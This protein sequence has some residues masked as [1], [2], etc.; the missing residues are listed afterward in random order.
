[1]SSRPGMT[2]VESICV[3]A[4]IVML[5]AFLV[6]AIQSVRESARNVQCKNNLRNLGLA[7]QNY[8]TSFQRLP[9]GSLGFGEVVVAG[10]EILSAWQ[11][12]SSYEYYWKNAQH[13]SWLTYLLAFLEQTELNDSLPK[14]FHSRTLYGDLLPSPPHSWIGEWS[15]VEN[16]MQ[17][18]VP[19]L[20]CPTDNLNEELGPS[21]TAYIGAQPVYVVD[22]SGAGIEGYMAAYLSFE[23]GYQS[24][25]YIGCSGAYSGGPVPQADVAKFSGSMRCRNGLEL[26]QIRDGLSQT[27]LLGETLGS[28]SDGTR[29]GAFVWAFGCLGRG[30]G[31]LPWGKIAHP[32]NPD[33]LLFGDWH[34]ASI[35]GFGSKHPSSLN[36]QFVG[37]RT[38]TV[39]R[40]IDLNVWYGLCGIRDGALIGEF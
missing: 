9:P 16:A 14:S 15:G 26:N 35:V 29:N 12:D 39:D 7:T 20:A 33:I 18:R 2:L 10:V 36:V 25:N 24:T 6:P 38:E 3:M 27:V 40:A 19:G 21:D 13:S 31:G 34:T 32:A 1:M 23:A 28:I 22:S 37:G 30:R 5:F 4:I 17:Q 11:N 8:E